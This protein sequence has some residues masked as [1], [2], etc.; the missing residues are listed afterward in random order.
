MFNSE[1]SL[2]VRYGETDQMSY[3]Y[4][5]N[6]AGY[7]EVARTE[8]LRNLGFSYKSIEEDGILMPGSSLFS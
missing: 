4:Y 2:R 8:A 6:Y 3:V 7:F 1:I 5:G